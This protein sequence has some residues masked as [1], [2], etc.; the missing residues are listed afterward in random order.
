MRIMLGF[1]WMHFFNNKH[2]FNNDYI[3]TY[4]F[5]IISIIWF[6]AGQSKHKQQFVC[7][8]NAHHVCSLCCWMNRQSLVMSA[9][10]KTRY[11]SEY[12]QRCRRRRRR[13]FLQQLLQRNRIK[14][15]WSLILIEVIYIIFFVIVFN[16]FINDL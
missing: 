2:K 3:S 11:S 15:W 16:T 7:V 10:A 12:T 8:S 14:L 6:E 1:V 13:S 4:I 5:W 9:I